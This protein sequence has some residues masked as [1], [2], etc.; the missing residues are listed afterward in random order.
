M[1]N[2]RL[3]LLFSRISRI[4]FL[5]YFSFRECINMEPPLYNKKM[6]SFHHWR[7]LIG[8]QLTRCLALASYSIWYV[9]FNLHAVCSEVPP[10]L[11]LARRR[12]LHSAAPLHG[13]RK[14][15]FQ[16][17]QV[18]VDR[19]RGRHGYPRAAMGPLRPGHVCPVRHV[20]GGGACGLEQLGCTGE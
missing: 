4:Y 12:S 8:K 11:H 17:L 2:G 13:L 6:V 9:C 10:A 19:H 5:S 1:R 15:G 16:F 18:R 20:Q 14:D 7:E 3:Y